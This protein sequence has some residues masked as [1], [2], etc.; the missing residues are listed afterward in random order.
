MKKLTTLNII[1]ITTCI[2][3][4]T[5]CKQENIVLNNANKNKFSKFSKGTY[6][7]LI[8]SG[9][10]ELN[11]YVL[12]KETSDSVHY[13]DVMPYF[14]S[15]DNQFYIYYLKNIWS[16]ATSQ[17]HP[18]YGVSTNNFYSYTDLSGGELLSSSSNGCD[19]DFS[20]GTGSVVKSGSTYYAFYSAHNPNY[21]SSCVT[22]AEGIMLATSS[23]LN[24][25]YTKQSSFTTLYPP[26]GLN[27]DEQ[28]NFR[29]PY[30]F[31]DSSA[32]KY[33]M[34]VAARNNENGTWRGVII[35]YTSTDLYHWSYQGIIYDGGA[36]NYFMMETPQMFKIGSY[37]YLIFSDTNTKDV[38]YRKSTSITGPWGYPA[39]NDRIEGNGIY[40]AKVA[41]D[42]N[43]NQ[44]IFGWTNS[45]VG[46]V[47]SGAWNWGGNMVAHQL[48]QQT[49]GDLTIQ[50]PSGVKTYMENQ[51]YT[52][53]VNSQWGNVTNTITGTNSYS[54]VS[55][56]DMNISNVIFNPVNLDR[57]KISAVV[58]YS[59]AS[60]DFGFMVGACDGYNNFYSLR[61]V[62]SQNRF[63]FDKVNR[64]SLTATTVATNDVPIT[65]APNTNYNVDIVVE[66]SMVIIYL[67]NQVALS[68]RIYKAR[69]TN[70]GIFVDHSHATFNYIDVKYH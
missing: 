24:T 19:P 50:M 43:G 12:Y 3:I 54:L 25:A 41:A 42:N 34:L 69:R 52:T 66:N 37:Y 63:S 36:I 35:D 65:L 21:P 31:Y 15:S 38:L 62:P 45:L 47:D 39:G 7:A 17:H 70:W 60:K 11:S 57:Y 58:S 27:F 4:L 61:F 29:D 59:S 22:K 8:C 56:T 68:C 9:F 1:I 23:S 33:Y 40:A 2:S 18:W 16:D 28:N 14:N 13:G 6:D 44:Y 30:V 55:D 32:S 64:S 5:A 51:V 67:N 26:T 20:V 53:T 10:P 48:V 49:N 46:N